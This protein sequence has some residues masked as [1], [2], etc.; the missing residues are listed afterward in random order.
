MKNALIAAAVLSLALAA[1]AFSADVK[2]PP[3]PSGQT[4]EQRQAQIL[5]VLDERISGLQEGRTCVQAA[6]N[7]DDL[8]I[9]RQKHRA[10]MWEKRGDMKMQGGPGGPQRGMMGGPQG[11]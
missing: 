5:K 6:K 3:N 4:F 2:Q 7:D 10:E 11:Q 8:R 1:P 9:C